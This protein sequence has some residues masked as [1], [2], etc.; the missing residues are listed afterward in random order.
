M[1]ILIFGLVDI[2]ELEMVRRVK[3]R[4][5]VVRNLIPL[6]WKLKVNCLKPARVLAWLFVR[7]R[8]TRML[9]VNVCRHQLFMKAKKLMNGN[10]V[11]LL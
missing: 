4:A 11:V 1:K 5:P 3:R 7:G 10:L 6:V 9:M 2:W 8:M